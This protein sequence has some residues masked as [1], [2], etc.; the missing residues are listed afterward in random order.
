MDYHHIDFYSR[1]IKRFPWRTRVRVCNNHMDFSI[2][3]EQ[4]LICWW[5]IGVIWWVTMDGANNAEINRF[6]MHL[7]Y[8]MG[9][10]WYGAWENHHLS[11]SMF[12]V[13]FNPEH[14][15]KLLRMVWLCTFKNKIKTFLGYLPWYMTRHRDLFFPVEEKHRTAIWPVLISPFDRSF[16]RIW[17]IVLFSQR[18]LF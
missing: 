17:Q 16:L 2:F 4:H 6:H 5:R 9:I 15:T 7:K 13:R 10:S 3:T 12:I 18:Q 14:P 11:N 1:E 8:R